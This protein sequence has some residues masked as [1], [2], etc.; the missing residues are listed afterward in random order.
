M[1]TIEAIS[2]TASAI[3]N[4]TVTTVIAESALT[5]DNTTWRTP[6]IVAADTPSLP[7]PAATFSSLRLDVSF[8]SSSSSSSV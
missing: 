1:I 2:S 7:I 6:A 8:L 5:N 3:N 4:N